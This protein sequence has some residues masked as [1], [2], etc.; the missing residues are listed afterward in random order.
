VTH[1][2]EELYPIFRSLVVLRLASDGGLMTWRARQV[3]D[4]R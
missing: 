4:D 1:L 3:G 2:P